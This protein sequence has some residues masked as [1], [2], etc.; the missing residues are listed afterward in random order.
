MA[1]YFVAEEGTER[2]KIG[3]TRFSPW[4]RLLDIQSTHPRRLILMRV[5]KG[6]AGTERA[7]HKAFRCLRIKGEWFTYSDAMWDFG[8]STD[9]GPRRIKYVPKKYKP[10][11]DQPAAQ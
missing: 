10:G 2:V 5:I 6:D 3:Y 11:V 1:V 9:I 7:A 4:D 8:Q